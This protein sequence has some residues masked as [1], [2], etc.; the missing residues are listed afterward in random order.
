MLITNDIK[1]GLTV[2]VVL[3]PQAI[4]YA[5]LAG[6]PPIY[7][8]YASLVPLIV[9]GVLGSSPHMAVGVNAIDMLIIA[10]GVAALSTPRTDEYVS[11]VI[12]L[13]VVTGAVQVTMGLL[14]MGFIVTLLSRPVATGFISG[15]ALI[16]ALNQLGSLTGVEMPRSSHVH[17][18]FMG[19]ASEVASMDGLTTVIGILSLIGITWLKRVRPMFPAGLS[20]VVVAAAATWIWSLDKAGVAVV[21]SVPAG[22]PWPAVPA[23]GGS[24]IV[25]LLP[26]AV[27][28]ALFQF[29]TV[30]SLGRTYAA[31]GGYRVHANQ[32][33]TA[34]GASNVIGGFFQAIPVS[35]S[36]SRTSIL[37]SFGETTKLANT[38]AAVVVGLTIAFLTPL[39]RFVPEAAL[40]AL[41]ISAVWKLVEWREVRYLLRVKRSDGTIALVTFGATVVL[42]V[43]AGIGTGIA[44]SV[45]AIMYRLS[46]PHVAVLGHIPGSR[47]YRDVRRFRRAVETEGVLMLRLDASFSFAN[48]DYVRDRVLGLVRRNEKIR[49]VVLDGSGINDLDMTAAEILV[50][51]AETLRDLGIELYL[52]GLKGRVRDTLSGTELGVRIGEDHLV[53]TPHRAM[54]RIRENHDEPVAK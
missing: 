2:G 17:I 18:L 32:D 15:A 16:I 50:D 3:V 49:W 46:R 13:A 42:G 27:G 8:L 51:I 6:L 22:L 11:L 7:G 36:F 54:K 35:G 1:A 52:T 31:K 34:I 33:L 23:F 37:F 41:I 24:E 26:T 14:R 53:M 30:A 47:S 45:L 40:A 38:I 48:A 5:I 39:F 9:Y 43:L 28:L 20:A 29:M 44:A 4:A 25:G 19:F 10:G 12:L 21:G